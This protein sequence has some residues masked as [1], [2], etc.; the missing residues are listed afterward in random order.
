MDHLALRVPD[1]DV[2]VAKAV[3]SGYEVVDTFEISLKD[4]S[5]AQ[6]KALHHP[7]LPDMFVTSG[8]PGSLIAEWVEDHGG[9]DGAI[10]HLAYEVPDVA[11]TMSEWAAEGVKFQTPEPITCSCATPLVQ[12][13]TEEDPATGLVYELITRNGHPGF[14]AEN[15]RRLMQGSSE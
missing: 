11:A 8:P 12:I 2:A 6:S 15:V 13:F 1:R 9:A 14:C 10:H 3:E 4:G 7:S 5:T